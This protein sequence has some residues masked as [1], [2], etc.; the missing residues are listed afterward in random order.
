MLVREWK[1]TQTGCEND[2]KLKYNKSVKKT[3]K[4]VN[5]I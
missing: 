3:R 4:N 5:D 1:Y 2:L